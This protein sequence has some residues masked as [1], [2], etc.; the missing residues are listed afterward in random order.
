VLNG[1]TFSQT[2]QDCL[3]QCS[4]IVPPGVSSGVGGL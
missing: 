3:N 1:Q 4:S 2:S